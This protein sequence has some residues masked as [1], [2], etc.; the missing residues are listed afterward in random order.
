MKDIIFL[1]FLDV[2]LAVFYYY[3]SLFIGKKSTHKHIIFFT[4][5]KLKKGT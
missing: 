4:L 5:V 2:F 3:F 1:C